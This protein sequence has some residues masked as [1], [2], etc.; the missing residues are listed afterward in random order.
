MFHGESGAVVLHEIAFLWPWGDTNSG[1]WASFLGAWPQTLEGVGA[2]AAGYALVRK[3]NCHVKGC[4]RLG[5][6]PV[7]G[8]N[9][10]TCLHHH[11]ADDA[12]S[13]EDVLNAHT[14]HLERLRAAEHHLAH[15]DEQHS[16]PDVPEPE[17]G[18]TPE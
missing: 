8:T 18:S 7:D 12:P 2:V 10:I 5:R 15:L 3:H 13:S 14:N 11:P 17:P 4:P 16:T 6:H 9:Y 1:R